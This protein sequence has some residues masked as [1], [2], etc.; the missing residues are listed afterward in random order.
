MGIDPPSIEFSF[1]KGQVI[2]PEPKTHTHKAQ[3]KVNAPGISPGKSPGKVKP[4]GMNN[5]QPSRV[6]SKYLKGIDH[7]K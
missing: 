3:V 7:N 2:A 5:S 4:P 6:I 1:L